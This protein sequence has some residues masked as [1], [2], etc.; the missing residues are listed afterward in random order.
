MENKHLFLFAV[1]TTILFTVARLVEMKFVKQEMLPMKEVISDVL[2]VFGSAIVAS[3]G[4]G[5]SSQFFG[6]LMNF[7]TENKGAEIDA[8]EIF[9]NPPEF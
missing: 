5:Y 2:V 3:Y 7:V 4:Y 8:P 6:N 9:T 1:Y